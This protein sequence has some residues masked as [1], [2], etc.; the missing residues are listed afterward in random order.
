MVQRRE[1]CGTRGGASLGQAESVS[2][3]GL[4]VPDGIRTAAAIPVSDGGHATVDLPG[5]DPASARVGGELGT[6][7]DPGP[8][9]ADLPRRMTATS[10]DAVAHLLEV[11]AS[12]CEL[13]ED[14]VV[15]GRHGEDWRRS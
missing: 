1:G 14:R 2:A 13:V 3:A 5:I 15:L 10:P 9:Q 6:Q 4:V 7:G 8:G 12:R 11:A